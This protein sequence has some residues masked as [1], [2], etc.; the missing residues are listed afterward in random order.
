MTA[1]FYGGKLEGLFA[2]TTRQN[3]PRMK[4]KQTLS[5]VNVEPLFRDLGDVASMTGTARLNIDV[6]ATGN[7]SDQMISN[8]DGRI[9]FG[10]QNGILRGINITWEL[11][12]AL[13]LI[14]GR[15]APLKESD[16]TPFRKISGKGIIAKGVLSNDDLLIATPGLKLTGAGSIDLNREVIDYDLVGEVPKGRQATESGLEDL[17]GKRI[18]IKISGKLDDPSVR[19]DLAKLIGAEVGDFLIKQLGLGKDKDKDNSEDGSVDEEKDDG[20]ILEGALKDLF[21]K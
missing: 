14:K 13:A 7:T 2:L 15:S 3:P 6:S 4:I 11:Q 9:G 12:R 20:N 1:D 5:D 17:A 10:V 19:P 8:L 18:P 21:G 16:D